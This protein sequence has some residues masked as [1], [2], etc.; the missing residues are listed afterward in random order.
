MISIPISPRQAFF[1]G[2][3]GV[4]KTALACA[5][6]IS[7]ADRGQRVLL[8]STDPASNLDEMLAVPLSTEPA[9]VSGSSPPITDSRA[10]MNS[11]LSAS[12]AR[13]P[14]R[15][16]SLPSITVPGSSWNAAPAAISTV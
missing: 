15:S 1:T 2:K 6:A 7:L 9:A 8:I 10:K 13:A 3:G 4:G 5:V 16:R 12:S 11:A 14:A